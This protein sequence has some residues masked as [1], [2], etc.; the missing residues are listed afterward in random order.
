MNDYLVGIVSLQPN[1]MQPFTL[2]SGSRLDLYIWKCTKTVSTV[3][4]PAHVWNYIPH[5]NACNGTS[6][7]L[8]FMG[9][10]MLYPASIMCKIAELEAVR[11][12]LEGKGREGKS[13]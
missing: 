7:G 1:L 6:Q 5:C 3:L 8:V 2:K 4:D 12:N 13:V 10:C 11:E 9:C